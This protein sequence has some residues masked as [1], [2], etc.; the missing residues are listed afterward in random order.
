MPPTKLVRTALAAVGAG[1]VLAVVALPAAYAG[2]DD[3][4]QS[5][6]KGKTAGISGIAVSEAAVADGDVK[7]V[8]VRDN[9]KPDE[10]R[11]AAVGYHDGD[12]PDVEPLDWKGGELPA[13]LEALTGIPGEKGGHLAAT[14]SGTVYH[15]RVAGGEAKVVDTFELPAVQSGDEVES[16]TLGT[17]SPSAARG[18][19]APAA[20]GKLTA[21]WGGR[22]EDDRPGTLHAALLS[23]D[24]EGRADFGK[25]QS[26]EVR[27]PYPAENVRHA[28]DTAAADSGDLLVSSASDPGDDGPFDSAVYVAGRVSLDD[29]GALVLTVAKDPEVLRKFE[30]HKIEA[31][32]CLPGKDKAILG[33]DDENEG[34]SLTTAGGVC[35]K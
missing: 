23:F 35:G 33:T 18:A 26:A 8:V 5:A 22:G 31:L 34:G 30:K 16:L 21:V 2:D 28:S 17:A 6:G 20:E 11:V 25:V 27:A 13:D 24:S 29:S 12:K 14:S 32:A 19:R 10:N 9:K 15:L 7:A 4:W 3:G 1:T